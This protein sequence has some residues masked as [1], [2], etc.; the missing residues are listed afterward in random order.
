M[1]NNNYDIIKIIKQ[2]KKL[3]KY[4]FVKADSVVQHGSS[5]EVSL[6]SIQGV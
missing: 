3:I 1:R 5:V 6:G 4:V 2:I